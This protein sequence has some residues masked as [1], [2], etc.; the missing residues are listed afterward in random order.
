LVFPGQRITDAQQLAF[1]E[2]FGPLESSIR[3][4]RQNKERAERLD[5]R[6]SDISNID[7]DNKIV[8]NDDRRR[9]GQLAN[10]LW[11][12]DSSFKAV[13]ARY[14]LLSARIVPAEGGETE[15]A[16]LR[17]AYDALPDKTKAEIDDLV[18]EHWYLHSRAQIGFGDFDANERAGLEPVPQVVVRVHPGSARKTLYL[19]SHAEHI[20]GMPVPEG[21]LLLRDLMEHATQPQFV[22]RHHWK[23]G[24]LV[25]W[26]DRCTM[27]R[28]RPWDPSQ[29][30]DMHRTTVSDEVSTLAQRQAVAAE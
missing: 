26:D 16:D 7:D 19:A 30:R 5:I 23:V 3:R 2:R 1:S 29:V 4:L 20:I 25:M 8:A 13:P 21:R 22:Y 6:V 14:S 10:Q 11:H 15:F 24:D 27:H 28:G 12:T 17:A 18:A 9:M